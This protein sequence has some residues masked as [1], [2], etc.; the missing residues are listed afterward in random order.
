[1]SLPL[2]KTLKQFYDRYAEL[3]LKSQFLRQVIYWQHQVL[4]MPI[5]LF[6]QLFR[7]KLVRKGFNFYAH[8]VFMC[9]Y[10]RRKDTEDYWL[11]KEALYW[12]FYSRYHADT[13]QIDQI[14]Q[15]PEVSAFLRDD[16]LT[17]VELGFGIG[18]NYRYLR[19]HICL[20][21]YIAIE[22]NSFACKYA[23]AE[24]SEPNFKVLNQS[25]EE[26]TNETFPFEVL[27]VFGRVLMYLPPPVLAQ[28]IA[29]LPR[30]GVRKILVLAEGSQGPDRQFPDGTIMYNFRQ[31]LEAAGYAGN[32]I[33]QAD[34]DGILE[35]FVLY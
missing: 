33:E 6:D 4:P 8:H 23:A 5:A 1:M 11:S 16:S 3:T 32:Y 34:A 2:K 24:Y 20:K 29:S 14:L 35:R 30:R 31:R 21:K 18:R 28:L 22:L 27:L 19:N 17:A 12:F 15:V 10:D 7:V 26:F 13:G 9:A 25:I